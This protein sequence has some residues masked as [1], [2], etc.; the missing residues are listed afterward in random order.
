M[1]LDDCNAPGHWI[2]ALNAAENA[3]KCKASNDNVMGQN[4]WAQNLGLD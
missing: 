2:T 1:A 3:R 4:T